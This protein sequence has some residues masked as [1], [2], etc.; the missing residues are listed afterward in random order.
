MSDFPGLFV[1]NIK[2]NIVEEE[3]EK[4]TGIV[5]AEVR[6]EASNDN[7]LL[8]STNNDSVFLLQDVSFEE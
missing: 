1:L 4:I 7:H 8:D 5:L 2:D 3:D 6:S